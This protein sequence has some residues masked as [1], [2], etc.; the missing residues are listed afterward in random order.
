MTAITSSVFKKSFANWI[1]ASSVQRDAASSP[2]TRGTSPERTID[3]LSF[4]LHPFFT[5]GGHDGVRQQ[6]ESSWQCLME[7][8]RVMLSAE[9]RLSVESGLRM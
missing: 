6:F 8:V 4:L 1:Q 5:I 3:V 7:E 2:I 9:S